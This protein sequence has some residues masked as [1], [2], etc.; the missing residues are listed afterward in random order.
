VT[1]SFA[2]DAEEDFRAVI[3]FI[4]EH[5]LTA[6]ADFSERL[7]SVIDQLEAG[8]F[9]GPEVELTAGD[10]LRSWAVPP[11]RI[12]YQRHGDVLWVARIYHQSRSPIAR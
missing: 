12:Y 9:D 2:P 1:V 11:V 4:A 10:V 6:A 5:N 7:F 8:D 3:D